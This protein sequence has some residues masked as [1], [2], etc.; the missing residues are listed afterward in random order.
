MAGVRRLLGSVATSRAAATRSQSAAG[1]SRRTG[2]QPPRRHW[3][4]VAAAGRERHGAVDARPG[5]GAAHGAARLRLL[6][7]V[8]AGGVPVPRLSA[9]AAV[10]GAK[11]LLGMR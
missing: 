7:R 4:L 8:A 1:S 3:R 5:R 11:L 10:Q 6:R 2:R 9:A